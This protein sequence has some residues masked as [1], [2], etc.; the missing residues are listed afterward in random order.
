MFLNFQLRT[1]KLL[2]KFS[3]H[4]LPFGSKCN[5]FFLVQQYEKKQKAD[6]KQSK[7]SSAY[8]DDDFGIHCREKIAFRNRKQPNVRK[9]LWSFHKIP[10]F[11]A[12]TKDKY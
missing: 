2:F 8:N 1:Q 6:D 9:T 12:E 11:F 5:G 7:N 3:F 10:T 4:Q